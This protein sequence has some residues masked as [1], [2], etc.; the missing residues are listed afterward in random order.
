MHS[1]VRVLVLCSSCE[2]RGVG[3]VLSTQPFCLLV[4]LHLVSAIEDG[5]ATAVVVE[6][7]EYRNPTLVV[8]PELERDQLAVIR[9]SE[10]APKTLRAV[11]LPRITSPLCS[12]QPLVLRG[13][14]DRPARSRTGRIHSIRAHGGASTVLTDIPAAP[15]DSGSCVYS[16][17]QLIGLCQGRVES[18]GDGSAI[19]IAFSPDGLR[20][21][22]C[23][24]SRQTRRVSVIRA[25]SAGAVLA[26]L[27]GGIFLGF[28]RFPLLVPGPART[29]VR[30][31]S[32]VYEVFPDQDA[33]DTLRTPIDGFTEGTIPINWWFSRNDD[34][35]RQTF[36]PVPAAR[37]EGQTGVRYAY[38]QDG[39]WNTCALQLPDS[40]RP[41][42]S[43]LYDAIEFVA[44]ADQETPLGLDVSFTDPAIPPNPDDPPW[45]W[46]CNTATLPHVIWL[47]DSFRTFRVPF[48]D[49]HVQAWNLEQHPDAGRRMNPATFNEIRFLLQDDEGVLEI[50]RVHLVREAGSPIICG[51]ESLDP[52]AFVAR[53]QDADRAYAGLD[54]VDLR[55]AEAPYGACCEMVW[56]SQSHV[57]LSF[58]LR[59]GTPPDATGFSVVLAASQPMDV[60][61]SCC[62]EALDVMGWKCM[63]SAVTLEVDRLPRRFAVPFSSFT[64]DVQLA[65]VPAFTPEEWQTVQSLVLRPMADEGT[66]QVYEVSTLGPASGSDALSSSR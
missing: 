4:P 16:G 37:I 23:I 18:E 19:V 58:Y 1:I 43:S 34:E 31:A 5:D 11:R 28:E 61:V 63:A 36:A 52:D 21:L 44:R 3:A 59:Q 32:D 57:D 10:P 27:I 55:K 14:R 39:N 38:P 17:S 48:N 13:P 9:F 2:D 33:A 35:E 62:G 50:L 26:I 7:V 24:R 54:L 47:S 15:G 65:G 66:L 22:W 49:F 29:S 56:E 53:V 42:D 6:G 51:T 64:R 60:R 46:G 8:P 20:S 40:H 30:T 12:G 41:V 25:G 45:I